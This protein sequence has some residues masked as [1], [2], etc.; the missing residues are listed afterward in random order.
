VSAAGVGLPEV[1]EG[2]ETASEL[3]DVRG[4]SALGG[5][6]RRSWD[7]LYLMAAT[8][9]KRTYFGTVLGYVWSLGRPFLLFGVLLV[10]FTQAFHL[11][12][13]VPHYAVLLL[14]NIVLF[15]F[16]Q[17]S[18]TAAV[19]SIVSQ[20]AIVRKTQFPRLVIP[21]SVVLTAMFNLALN[22]VVTFIFIAAF[23]VSPRW[24]WLL[25]VVTIALLFVLST[26]VSMILSSLYPR[27][28]DLGIIWSVFATALFYATPILYPLERVS[29]TMRHIVITFNP[30]ASIL[31]LARR[32]VIDPHAPT[33]AALAGGSLRLLVPI[34]IYLLTCAAAVIIFRR[35]APRIAEAL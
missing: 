5:G 11:G 18:T 13:G 2:S 4:P 6:W 28:R 8:E 29:P 16:F 1:A 22:L 25:I 17:E 9:F 32:W 33:P 26:A 23:G 7:L 14:M 24:T 10:V 27:F 31:E 20:E 35:E 12:K 15:G 34:A 30:L 3:R 21:V 19:P